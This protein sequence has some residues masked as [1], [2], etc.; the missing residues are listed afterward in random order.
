MAVDAFKHERIA[1]GT[2]FH[3]VDIAAE[4]LFL[5]GLDVEEC[6]EFNQYIW[7]EFD[8]EVRIAA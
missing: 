6:G 8:Q 7:C 3:K 5:L 4:Q 2:S 1:Y